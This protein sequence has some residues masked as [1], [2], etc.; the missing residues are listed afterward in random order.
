VTKT[1]I[2]KGLVALSKELRSIRQS[3]N[4]TLLQI[5]KQIKIPMHI[6]HKLE[7]L[8]ATNYPDMDV[9]TWSSL[10]KYEN[11]VQQFLILSKQSKP[12]QDVY[13]PG[14]LRKNKT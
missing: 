14:Y 4:M 10:S 1:H 5:S 8:S 6:L 9:D 2:E 3:R 7:T 13:V 12:I 11:Q